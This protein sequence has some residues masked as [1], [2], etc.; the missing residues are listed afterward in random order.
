MM[1]GDHSSI[2]REES[3]TSTRRKRPDVAEAGTET[4]LQGLAGFPVDSPRGQPSQRDDDV[5]TSS[6]V[7]GANIFPPY[8][9]VVTLPAT[10]MPL[11][12]RRCE[13]RN[14]AE[15]VLMSPRHVGGDSSGLGEF[16]PRRAGPGEGLFG[17]RIIKA[18]QKAVEDRRAVGGNV[19]WTS[20]FLFLCF[21]LVGKDGT[22]NSPRHVQ[23]L[24]SPL[25]LAQFFR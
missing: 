16:E 14:R 3:L 19:Q 4:R 11:A 2:P 23:I 25:P 1:A 7:L 9:G 24:P 12:D 21:S 17:A 13:S 15:V 5:A 10:G 20:L 18:G 8:R 22:K 6:V